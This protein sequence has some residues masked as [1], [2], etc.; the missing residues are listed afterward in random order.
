MR[1][2]FNFSKPQKG[3]LIRQSAA[4]LLAVNFMLGVASAQAELLSIHYISAAEA[5]EAVKEA[6]TVCAQ[7]GYAVTATIVDQDAIRLAV[8][9]GD[10][11]GSHTEDVSWGKAYAAVSYAPIYGL[12]DS[13]SVA[14]LK[15]PQNGSGFQIPDHMVLRGGGVT[16]KYGSEVIGA[17]GV[18][19]S[20]GADLDEACA[21]AGYDKIKPTL[22][23]K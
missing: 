3:L 15:L 4:C 13:G 17:I 21:R 10:H 18:S 12:E 16:I 11:A 5:S 23:S 2:H 7:R 22:S 9:R 6:V 14:K 20:P 19:G 1:P 8:L